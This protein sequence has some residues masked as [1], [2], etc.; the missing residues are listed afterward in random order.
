[1]NLENCERSSWNEPGLPNGIFSNQI[2]IL[3]ALRIGN[4]G[5]V[6]AHLEYIGIFYGHFVILLVY[7][8]P[9]WYIVSRKIWQP[10]N[11]HRELE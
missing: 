7:C 4:V 10:W 6:Y 11:G 1:M 9:F 8:P 5:I 2:L 3:E